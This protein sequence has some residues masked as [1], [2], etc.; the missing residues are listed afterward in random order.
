MLAAAQNSKN[1]DSTNIRSQ[2]RIM[3]TISLVNNFNYAENL[4]YISILTHYS[5]ND[6]ITK[7][8][9]RVTYIHKK[10]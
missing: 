6:F 7:A 9:K 2:E 3:G 1:N 4:I 5:N 10:D 8:P